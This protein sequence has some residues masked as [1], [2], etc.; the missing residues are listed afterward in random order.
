M[1][2]DFRRYATLE[3][4]IVQLFQGEPNSYDLVIIPDETNLTKIMLNLLHRLHRLAS[5]VMVPDLVFNDEE[6]NG[7]INK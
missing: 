6:R 5:D 1:I 4:V 3:H 7:Y 2:V